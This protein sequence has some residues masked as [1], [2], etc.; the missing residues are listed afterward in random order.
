VTEERAD[1]K[2]DGGRL[3][4]A[5]AFFVTV[6]EER[7]DCYGGEEEERTVFVASG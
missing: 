7:A 5:F 3:S 2:L 6:R 4:V 1:W